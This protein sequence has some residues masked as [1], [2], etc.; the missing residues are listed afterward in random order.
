[1]PD[2]S[3][4]SSIAV[5]L[6]IMAPSVPHHLLQVGEAMRKP[7]IIYEESSLDDAADIMVQRKIHRIAVVDQNDKL[8]GI[9]SRSDILRATYWSF[10]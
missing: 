8:V 5:K 3:S 6:P 9:V 7:C 2:F 4:S 10:K 1:M